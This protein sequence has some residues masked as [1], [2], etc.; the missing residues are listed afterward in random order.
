MPQ[1]IE[2]SL[3]LFSLYGGNCKTLT[4]HKAGIDGVDQWSSLSS[5]SPPSPR[6]E[7]LYNVQPGTVDDDTEYGAAIRYKKR[8]QLRRR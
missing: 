5:G 8:S 7:M 1:V 6:R 2:Q 4:P 3:L